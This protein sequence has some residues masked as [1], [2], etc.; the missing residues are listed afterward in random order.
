MLQPEPVPKSLVDAARAVVLNLNSG[1][2]ALHVTNACV[3]NV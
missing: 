2:T 1:S 3:F